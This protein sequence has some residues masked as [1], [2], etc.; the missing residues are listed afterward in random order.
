MHG[1]AGVVEMPGFVQVVKLDMNSVVSLQGIAAG[2]SDAW[3]MGDG[4][5]TK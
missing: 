3:C 1:A 4:S 2:E 5:D